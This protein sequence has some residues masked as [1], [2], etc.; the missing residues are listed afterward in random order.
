MVCIIV[1]YYTFNNEVC[2][3]KGNDEPIC[4]EIEEIFEFTNT[5]YADPRSDD[6]KYQIVDCSCIEKFDDID[7]ARLWVAQ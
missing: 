2:S 3:A 7:S 6:I 1:W 5:F 4:R